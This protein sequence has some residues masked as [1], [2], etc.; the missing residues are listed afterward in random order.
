MAVAA[1]VAVLLVVRLVP[2]AV[3]MAPLQHRH[4]VQRTLAV[5][6]AALATRPLAVLVVVEL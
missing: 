1:V 5:V 6:A 4:R 2:V 3:D